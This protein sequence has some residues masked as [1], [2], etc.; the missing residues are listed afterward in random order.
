MR[1]V[2]TLISGEV[3]EAMLEVASQTPAGALV[4]VG[5]YRGGSAR[6]LHGLAERQQRVLYLYD[7]F[8]G[9][10]YAND[11]DTHAVG[12]FS[13]CDVVSVQ[14]A[15]P[16]AVITPGIFPESAVEMGPIAFA[17][18]DCDQYRSYHE[19]IDY[20]LPRM[21][22]GGVL[23]FDDSTVLRGANLAVT[24]C[25]GERLKMRAGKHYLEVG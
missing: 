13:D 6:A 3:L 20:L 4:E 25:F 17:H 14:N 9:I 5:V 1:S 24:E 12:E 22:S 15:C 8:A 18:L 23:W 10:P 2:F 16:S 19:S 7:T 11:I 21:V